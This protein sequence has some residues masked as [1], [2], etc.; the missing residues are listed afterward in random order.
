MDLV[1][2]PGNSSQNK[3]WI[4]EVEQSLKPHFSKTYVQYYRHWSQDSGALDLDHEL[5]V[6]QKSVKKLGDYLIFAKSAGVVLAIK[7][8]FEQK[9]HPAK[10]VFAGSAIFFGKSLGCDMDKYLSQY[11]IPTL[12]IQ[13]TGDTAISFSDLKEYLQNVGIQ[14]YEMVELSGMDHHYGDVDRL[15]ELVVDFSDSRVNC[16]WQV[17]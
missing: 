13:K 4:D 14:N 9:I 8:I 1:L 2:L 16:K 15:R 5:G 11:S 7:G 10:C 3:E 12:F 6:L 17:R